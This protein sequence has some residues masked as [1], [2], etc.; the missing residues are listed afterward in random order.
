MWLSNESTSSFEKVL[1][2][3]HGNDLLFVFTPERE[4]LPL[5]IHHLPVAVTFGFI[6]DENIVVIDPT[7]YEEA[8]MGGSM[9]ATLNTNGDVCA[10]QKAGGAGVLQ[11]SIMQCLRIASVKA[12]FL[13]IFGIIL[14]IILPFSL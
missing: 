14:D 10:I 1:E 13:S 6:G 2:V 8:V 11:S 4:P 9:T 3:L 12:G 7:H 5:I